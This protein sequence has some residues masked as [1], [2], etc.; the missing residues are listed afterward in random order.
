MVEHVAQSGIGSG[1]KARGEVVGAERV[2]L[3][4]VLELEAQHLDFECGPAHGRDFCADTIR[5]LSGQ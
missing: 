2:N 1:I 5:P 4:I 3:S